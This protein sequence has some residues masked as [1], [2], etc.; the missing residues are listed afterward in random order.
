MPQKISGEQE[1]LSALAELKMNL[2]EKSKPGSSLQDTLNV[3]TVVELKMLAKAY[4]VKGYTKLAKRGLIE[5]VGTA[6][7]NPNRMEEVLYILEPTEWTLLNKTA[8]TECLKTESYGALACDLLQSLGYIQSYYYDNSF[9]Y[10]MPS[11]IRQTYADL[12]KYG[13]V[14]R[15]ERSDLICN[16]AAAAI[17]L[18]G[19][20]SQNDFVAIFDSQNSVHTNID[21]VFRT[22]MRQI[23][24]AKSDYCFWDE[25]IVCDEFEDDDFKG[26]EELLRQISDKPRYIPEKREFL[27][28]AD[29]CYYESTKETRALSEYIRLTLEQDKDTTQAILDEIHELCAAEYPLQEYFSVFQEYEISLTMKQ[30]HEL[31]ELLTG[32]NNSTRLWRNNGHTPN[33]IFDK[34][35]RQTLQPLPESQPKTGKVG[36]NDPCPCGSGKKYKKCCLSSLS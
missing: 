25:Y 32:I 9:R 21:E 30:A 4:Y 18:Y 2:A 17:E 12:K 33:E 6:L 27:K 10:V 7:L 28:Y 3:K 26:V 11:E 15:K 8:M 13:I 5:S 22:L 1:L 31:S 35:E 14:A 24:V 29:P 20:I 16:Y 23:I 19:V 34:Y 36:R